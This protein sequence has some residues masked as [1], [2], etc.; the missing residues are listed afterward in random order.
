MKSILIFAA[1][2]TL[3]AQNPPRPPH[4]PGPPPALDAIQE[5]L[6]LS[7]AQ[8]AQLKQT[9]RRRAEA[10]RGRLEEMNAKRRQVDEM[11]RQG[12]SDA[13]AVGRLL[14]EVETHRKQ[15][16][17]ADEGFLREAGAVLDESQRAK[18]QALE[19]AAKLLPAVQEARALGLLTGG[20]GPNGVMPMRRPGPPTRARQ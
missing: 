2:V 13:A 17:G 9:M 15:L 14:L 4:R 18:L 7:D 20:A 5:Y 1:A 16:R 6:A 11:L 8:A 10:N 12:T 3:A 19:E